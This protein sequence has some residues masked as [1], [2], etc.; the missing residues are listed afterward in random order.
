M[1]TLL[2][3][4]LLLVVILTLATLVL[5]GVLVERPSGSQFESLVR[6]LVAEARLD[7]TT[8]LSLQAM[9]EAVHHSGSFPRQTDTE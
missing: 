3:L 4:L 9:R 8:H 6:R 1:I 7:A 5:A 2:I